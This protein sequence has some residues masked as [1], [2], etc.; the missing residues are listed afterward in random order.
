MG[1]IYFAILLSPA[2]NRI[3]H[4]HDFRDTIVRRLIDE[5]IRLLTTY[6]NFLDVVSASLGLDDAGLG[7][8]HLLTLEGA[9]HNCPHIRIY[10]AHIVA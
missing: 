7:G 6:P 1:Q 9:V 8:Y 5:Y 10:E 3:H 4:S 2:S